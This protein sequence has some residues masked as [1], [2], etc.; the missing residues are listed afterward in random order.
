[1]L[2]IQ[3][4]YKNEAEL[5]DGSKIVNTLK[6]DAQVN[7]GGSFVT[8]KA[9]QDDNYI[10]W[11]IAINESQSTIADAVVTDDPTDNQVLVE[12]SFHLYPTTVD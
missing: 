11:S 8:K 5:K 6:G 12:D 1:M 10:N 3:N 7:K 9:V 4:T 2:L